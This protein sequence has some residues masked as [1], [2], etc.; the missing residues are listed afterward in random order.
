[1]GCTASTIKSKDN[2]FNIVHIFESRDTNKNKL[3]LA[4]LNL[5]NNAESQDSNKVYQ[6]DVKS[7]NDASLNL[8]HS[9]DSNGKRKRTCDDENQGQVD[10]ILVSFKL[11]C[12]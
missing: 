11:K 2:C 4:A 1:M 3:D 12:Q 10:N 6:N 7:Q 8:H 5:N 9:T